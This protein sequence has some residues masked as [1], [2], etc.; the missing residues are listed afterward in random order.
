MGYKL[1]AAEVGAFNDDGLVVPAAALSAG[2]YER[3]R[4]AVEELIIAT[5][6]RPDYL[7]VAH[8]PKR[9][10]VYDG[11]EGG[12]KIFRVAI[13]P[14]LLDLVEQVLGPDVILWGSSM[15]GK[16]AGSGKRTQWHQDSHWWPM[17]P[18]VTCSVWMAVD[19][20]SRDNGCLQFIPGSHK[21]PVLPH[22][23][24][25]SQGVIGNSIEQSMLDEMSLRL[26]ELAP[27][28]F[29]MHQANLVHGSEENR[30]A[31]RR[32]GLVIRYMPATSHFDRGNAKSIE[33]ASLMKTGDRVNY[34]TRPIW[35]VRGQNRHPDNDFQA[36]HEPL[37]DLDRMLEESRRATASAH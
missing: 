1:T 9:P 30:S 24:E 3:V 26:V 27:G 34:G 25:K 22:L 7:G 8:I 12:E 28:R 23:D 36:G 21:W 37:G 20:S 35:L 13:D 15:F 4:A 2:L 19:E 14:E 32:A 6:D 29:S 11:V 33:Q 18:L 31:R 10:G 16:P 5:R 17:R